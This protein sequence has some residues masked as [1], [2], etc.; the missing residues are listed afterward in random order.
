MKIVLPTFDDT[1]C[2]FLSVCSMIKTDDK[3][4]SELLSKARE[5][6]AFYKATPGPALMR[7]C[8]GGESEKNHLHID[9][10][11]NSYFPNGLVPKKK[12]KKSELFDL[13]Q[14]VSNASYEGGIVGSF[15]VPIDKLP[16]G[17]L[18]KEI[19]KERQM[20]DTTLWIT[21]ATLRRKGAPF[22]NIRWSILENS[23]EVRFFITIMQEGTIA[24]NYLSD[25]LSKINKVFRTFI[26]LE[27]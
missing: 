27:Q 17:S 19:G 1:F 25:A 26:L 18:T 4:L 10:V 22:D 6:L 16:E 11:L 9:C 5:M 20:D 2:D 8:T 21:G 7:V 14:S 15:L 3:H 24:D 13:L 23:R 12:H